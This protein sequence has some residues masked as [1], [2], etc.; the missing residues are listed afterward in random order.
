MVDIHTTHSILSGR[1]KDLRETIVQKQYPLKKM[2]DKVV[3]SDWR[4]SKFELVISQL[5]TRIYQCEN[6][7]DECLNEI[8]ELIKLGASVDKRYGLI[9]DGTISLDMQEK[10]WMPVIWLNTM[11]W[12]YWSRRLWQSKAEIK[13]IEGNSRKNSCNRQYSIYRPRNGTIEKAK[14]TCA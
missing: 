9:G 5:K 10:L 8:N 12:R 1:V 3:E 4:K 13:T 11:Q 14:T 7:V 2:M 6:A